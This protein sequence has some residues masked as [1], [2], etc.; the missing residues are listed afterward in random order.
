V[1]RGRDE[2]REG[3]KRKRMLGKLREERKGGLALTGWAGTGSAP[4]MRLPQVLLAG[5]VLAGLVL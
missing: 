1:V 4:K 3:R 5:F 2:K